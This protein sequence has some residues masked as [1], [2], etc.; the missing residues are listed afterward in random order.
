MPTNEEKINVYKQLKEKANKY[1]VNI[2][3]C[4]V[5]GL[6]ESRCID[7]YL[8]EQFKGKEEEVDKKEPRKRELCSCTHFIDIG[9]WSPKIGYSKYNEISDINKMIIKQKVLL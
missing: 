1:N 9:G 4:C 2:E 6:D 5:K 7:G 3:S 8:L